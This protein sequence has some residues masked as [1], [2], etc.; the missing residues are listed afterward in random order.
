MLASLGPKE[1]K[2]AFLDFY[3]SFLDKTA[4]R[5][6]FEGPRSPHSLVLGD[7]VPAWPSLLSDHHSQRAPGPQSCDPITA[8]SSPSFHSLSQ[9]GFAGTSP[10]HCRL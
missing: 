7:S 8:W 1:A 4:V 9:A 3:H 10:S 6:T 2:K 5:D